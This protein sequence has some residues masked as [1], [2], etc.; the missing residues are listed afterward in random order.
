MMPDVSIATPP[1]AGGFSG[2]IGS[3]SRTIRLRHPVMVDAILAQLQRGRHDPTHRRIGDGWLRASRTPEGPVLIKITG[4]TDGVHG[5]AWGPGA[6]WALDQLPA[7]AGTD[8]DPS[9]FRPLTRHH[10]LVQAAD[11]FRHL[12]LGRTGLV[13]EALSAAII[14]QKVTGVEAYGAFRRLV[15]AYGEPAPGPAR[16]PG[17]AA[18]GMYVPPPPQTWASIPSWQ[19]LRSGVEANR[20]KTLVGAAGRAAAIERTLTKTTADADRALRSLPGIG[21]WT[22][23]EVRQRAHGDPDA[24]S[25]GDYHVGKNITWSLTGQVLDD[26]ACSEILEPYRGHRYRVQVLLGLMGLRR[27]RRAPRMMLPTHT[28]CATSGRR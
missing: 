10:L 1:R 24:W 23:A 22:C 6:Q 20:S 7:L 3:T 18:G 27:P 28:P 12:R 13:F 11:R 15:Q 16:E 8:D 17:S 4:R 5:R 2:S 21:A 9:G 14:E 25:I 19:F 26:D